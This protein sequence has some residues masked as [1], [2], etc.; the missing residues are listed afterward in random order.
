MRIPAEKGHFT[1]YFNEKASTVLI[2]NSAFDVRLQSNHADE[3]HKNF[4]KKNLKR[5]ELADK[6]LAY[7]F[8]QTVNP[9][10][11]LISHWAS[12]HHYR[13]NCTLLE[14]VLHPN[15]CGTYGHSRGLD[16]NSASLLDGR[17]SE[18]PVCP[19]CQ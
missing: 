18:P 17:D 16:C 15:N 2:N 10:S 19:A 14:C 9:R 12:F 11:T 6:F 3:S 4:R 13:S 7:V 5:E 1:I 8:R